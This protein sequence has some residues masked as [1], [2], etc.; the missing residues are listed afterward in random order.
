ML[1]KIIFFILILGGLFFSDN[2]FTFQKKIIPIDNFKSPLFLTK[3][4]KCFLPLHYSLGKLDNRFNL[5]SEEARQALL[6][7]E[8]IWEKAIRMNLLQY[9]EKANFK[10]NFIFDQRQER[11]LAYKK[12]DEQLDQVQKTKGKM[13]KEYQELIKRYQIKLDVYQ[14]RVKNFNTDLSQYNQKVAYWNKEG[15]APSDEYKKLQKEKKEL[16]KRR[17]KIETKR[18]ELNKLI[19]KINLLA[20]KEKKLVENYNSN[21]RKYEN[22]Y[23]QKCHFD[24]GKYFGDHIEIYQFNNYSDLILVLAHELGHALQMK[25]VINSHSIMYYLAGDQ[26]FKNLQPT[27]EDI[28]ELKKVLKENHCL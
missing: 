19:Q 21:V 8:S 3:K 28:E 11:T 17:N 4:Q 20:Q 18:K 27:K 22:N 13:S 12:L 24:Q 1:K 15:G 14:K 23:G 7:A 26:D 6:Q 2:F 10:I 16:D 25:H 5:T 9:D